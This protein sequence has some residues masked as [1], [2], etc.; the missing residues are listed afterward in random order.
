MST[1]YPYNVFGS[2]TYLP[3]E[4]QLPSA[5]PITNITNANP[6]VITVNNTNPANIY[7]PGQFVYLSVPFDYGMYQ[8]NTLT[9]LI[10]AVSGNQFTVQL[11]TLGFDPWTSPSGL[12]QPAS[13]SP[14][15]SQNIY[16]TTTE[17]FHSE[18]NSGN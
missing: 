6:A 8:V 1:V 9:V 12:A 17:P 18:D 15:G 2:N 10:T 13:L 7:V 16:N 4:I 11:N 5:I 3:P 14:A